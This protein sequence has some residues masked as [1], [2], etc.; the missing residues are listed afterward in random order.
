MSI[1]KQLAVLVVALS[2]VVGCAS[3]P[4]PIEPE[5]DTPTA[6]EQAAATAA[7]EAEAAKAAE[8]AAAAKDAAAAKA[9]EEAAAAKEA[10]AK[11]AAAKEA[12]AREAA[13][14]AAEEAALAAK[15]NMGVRGY[16]VEAGDSLWSISA[17][18][19][20][21]DN[22]YQWPLIYK[23]NRNKIKDADLIFPGQYFDIQRQLSEAD[24][25]GAINHARNRGS[26][27]L[28]VVEASD[29]GYLGE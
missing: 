10:A 19:E 14:K 11:E 21:Y 4:A 23:A 28:G 18:S 27:S 20:I 9:A 5:V 3:T 24:I 6:E 15:I 17:R 12:A 26:W 22:P 8:E 13:A 7:A 2:F 25:D 29:R 16:N 1:F